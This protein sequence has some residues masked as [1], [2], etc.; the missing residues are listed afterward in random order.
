MEKFKKFIPFIIGVV[1]IIVGVVVNIRAG[2]LA[3][4]CT[5]K[6]TATVVN[7]REDF[8]ADADTDGLRYM[9]YPV[10]EYQA[11]GQTVRGEMGS[12]S[13][14]P[15]YSI[16]DTAEILYNPSKVDEFIVAGENQNIA[17]IIFVGLG[18]LFIGAEIYLV[19]KK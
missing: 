15:A 1:L 2:E 3:R 18:V 12:G 19:V 9:Y 13:N 8:T 5:E 17:W 7:M 10:I 4:V 6:A 11:G 14:P 16:N